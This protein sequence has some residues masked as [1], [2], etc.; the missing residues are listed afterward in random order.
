MSIAVFGSLMFNSEQA[1]VAKDLVANS[2]KLN[3]QS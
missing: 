3:K 2:G 1:T